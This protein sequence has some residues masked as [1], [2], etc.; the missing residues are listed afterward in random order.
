MIF[1]YDY[2]KLVNRKTK[3]ELKS[4]A[5]PSLSPVVHSYVVPCDLL[6]CATGISEIGFIQFP[7][8]PILRSVLY[9]VSKLKC[10]RLTVILGQDDGQPSIA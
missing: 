3:S 10:P 1:I 6:S 8:P 7:F 5:F 2:Q 4:F 9:S